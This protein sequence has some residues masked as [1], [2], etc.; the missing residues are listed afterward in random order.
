ML[1]MQ[2]CRSKEQLYHYIA[3]L[4][5]SLYDTALYL[6]THP[7]C[8]E[9]LSYYHQLNKLMREAEKEYARLFGPLSMKDVSSEDD[10]WKWSMQPWPWEGGCK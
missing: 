2:A 3:M 7:D 9:A 1:T 5:F 10:Y 4:R 8:Q 6:D